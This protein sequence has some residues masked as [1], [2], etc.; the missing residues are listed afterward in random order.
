VTDSSNQVRKRTK[1]KTLWATVSSTVLWVL[2]F[3]LAFVIK[4]GTSLAFLPDALLLLGFFP[5]L[6]LWRRGWLTLLFGVFNT[7][8]GF[9]LLLLQY[10]P[11]EKFVGPMQ[12][13]RGH[14]LTMHSSWTWMLLG[15]VALVW[16][17]VATV[18][19]IARWLIL[20]RQS[21]KESPD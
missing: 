8:I 20:M 6:L 13:M 15:L 2:S 4:S 3:V 5:L 12:T 14:L 11:D 9:F 10:L 1:K 19:S 17:A 21:K 16:G 18:V 7:L